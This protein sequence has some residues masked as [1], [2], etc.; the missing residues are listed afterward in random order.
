MEG[1]RGKEKHLK[2]SS[3]SGGSSEGDSKARSPAARSLSWYK[4]LESKDDHTYIITSS[5]STSLVSSKEPYPRF[6][7]AAR[8][9]SPVG[10]GHHALHPSS[11]EDNTYGGQH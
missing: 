8:S 10:V 11:S 5:A 6:S 4:R 7:R 2:R 1:K 9:V 3:G